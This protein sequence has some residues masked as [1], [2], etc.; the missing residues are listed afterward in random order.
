MRRMGALLV[1][2][3]GRINF[4]PID[5]VP[6]TSVPAPSCVTQ[7]VGHTHMCAVQ[8]SGDTSC[9]GSDTGGEIGDGVAGATRAVAVPARVSGAFVHAGTGG[10]WSCWLAGDGSV[11]C[12]GKNNHGQLGRGTTTTFETA[13]A[14]IAGLPPIVELVV[15]AQHACGRTATDD[16]WCW[17]CSDYTSGADCTTFATSPTLA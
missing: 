6:D 8:A 13:V 16:M 10:H 3:C 11:S 15:G 12:A 1:V 7:L 14:Q 17:G 4:G 5:A 9:W 2:A